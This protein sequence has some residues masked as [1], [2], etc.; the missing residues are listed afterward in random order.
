MKKS[1][2]FRIVLIAICVALG[3]VMVAARQRVGGYKAI[4]RMTRKSPAGRAFAVRN[5]PER[6]LDLQLIA[7]R[8][9]RARRWPVSIYRICPEG[10]SAPEKRI[11]VD[12]VQLVRAVVFR[13][14]KKEYSRQVWGEEECGKDTEARVLAKREVYA[15][16]QTTP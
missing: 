11:D 5:R 14:L 10:A 3:A 9:Q 2:R 13:N 6:R 16:L 7:S 12:T 4:D 1:F 15:L 8:T